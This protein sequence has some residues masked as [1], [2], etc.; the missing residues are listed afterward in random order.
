MKIIY[1]TK[2]YLSLSL[3][4]T[5][6]LYIGCTDDVE[7]NV[8]KGI[9]LRDV[10]V[11][12]TFSLVGEVSPVTRSIAFTSG[13][14]ELGSAFS[15]AVPEVLLVK[16]KASGV[17]ESAVKTLWLGQYDASGNLLIAHYLSDITGNEVEV[18]LKES[19]NSSLRFV[20][21]AGDLG[22]IA[23]LTEFNET[24]INYTTGT[25]GLTTSAGLPVNLSC[26]N[27]AQLNNQSISINYE[28]TIQL[29]RMVTKIQLNYTI[30]S[31]FTFTLKQLYLRSVPTQIQ[32]NEPTGQVPGVTYQSFTVTPS[33][34]ASGTAEWYMPENKAGVI[35]SGKDGYAASTRDKKGSTVSVPN[36]TYIELIGDATVNGTTYKDVSFRIY[37]GNGIN[38]YNLKRNTPYIVNLTLGGIDLSDPRVSVTIPDIVAP[39]DIDAAVNS[40]TTIQATARPGTVWEIALP[41]WLSALADGKTN[42]VASGTLN[43]TGPAPVKFT[44]VTANPSSTER[45]QSFTIA[46]KGVTVKQKGSVLSATSKNKAIAPEGISH[47]D[48][49]YSFSATEGLSWALSEAIDW[50]TLTGTTTGVVSSATTTPTV[51][52][53]VTVNPNASTRTGYLFVKAGNAIGGTDAAL[54]KQIA[55]ITQQPSSITV[56]ANGGTIPAVGGSITVSGITATEGL[57]WTITKK[58]GFLD[59]S[60][61]S[62]EVAK[63]QFKITAKQSGSEAR[64]AVFT[65]SITNADPPRTFDIAVSQPKNGNNYVPGTTSLMISSS[66]SSGIWNNCNNYCNNTVTDFGYSDWRM[67]SRAE[68]SIIYKGKSEI[69]NTVLSGRYW[70]SNKGGGSDDPY[71]AYVDMSSGAG[72]D[73]NNCNNYCRQSNKIVCVR[74][75]Y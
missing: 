5:C 72:V 53:I 20:G 44:A 46:G 3:T 8:D 62:V 21:N 61:S 23:T 69:S 68:L 17:D 10:N 47:S 38:D 43:F 36:A 15:D 73:C 48:T 18:Q 37:P 41:A 13:E 54:E 35:A 58:S 32:C 12:F 11:R 74:G 66:Q 75:T 65:L 4:L 57:Q 60:F 1:L 26:A 40:T 34:G 24:K 70:G 49:E 56:P 63:G 55:A 71:A 28:Q 39:A 9:G 31:G 6:F 59:I 22:K 30:K 7:G 25:G 2:L 14:D 33:S 51:S 27:I 19:P 67:P 64:T 42:G 16:T 29:T 50:L 52:Y 45:N